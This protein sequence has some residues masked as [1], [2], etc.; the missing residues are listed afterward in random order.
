MVDKVD[1]TPLENWY[2]ETYVDFGE[3]LDKRMK[4]KIKTI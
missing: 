4:P 3:D 2:G 1:V